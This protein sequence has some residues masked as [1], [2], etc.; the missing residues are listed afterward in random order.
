MDFRLD[1]FGEPGLPDLI[2]TLRRRR[3]VQRDVRVPAGGLRFEPAAG[4]IAVRIEGQLVPMMP[5]AAVELAR[6]VGLGRSDQLAKELGR[7]QRSLADNDGMTLIRM[8]ADHAR[9]VLP[10]DFTILDHLELVE[11]TLAALRDQTT[12]VRL[13]HC[14]EDDGELF[15][16]LVAPDLASEVRPGD[17][18]YGGFALCSSETTLVDTEAVVRIFRVVCQNGALI[19]NNP[20]QRL[21]VPARAGSRGGGVPADWRDRL[22]QV[23]AQSFA[24]GTVDEETR[25]F[26]AT[27]DELVATPYEFLCNLVAQGLITEEEQGAIQSAFTEAGDFTLYGLINAVTSIAHGLRSAEAWLRAVAVERLGGEILRGDHQPP[28]LEPAYR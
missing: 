13:E 19:D 25:R 3:A 8:E 9:A 20:G 26:R 28:I 5:S 10:G 23:V 12:R 18:I 16:S 4:A 11:A 6:R 1:S 21:E 24:G 27:V 14:R 17:Y 7:V 2:E 22:R 15:L